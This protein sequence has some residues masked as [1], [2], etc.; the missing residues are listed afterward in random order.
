MQE[1][2][3]ITVS[4][5]KKDREKIILDRFLKIQNQKFSILSEKEAKEIYPQYNGE[6]P[7][8]IISDGEEYIGVELFSLI[9]QNTI[10][11]FQSRVSL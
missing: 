10:S 11:L 9:F 6:N 8:C 2:F 3:M 7:D 5:S 4:Q 1:K